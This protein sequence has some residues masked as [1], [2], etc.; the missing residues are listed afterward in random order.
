[1]K[2]DNHVG[3][4]LSTQK[5][6]ISRYELNSFSLN[7]QCV[8]RE[9]CVCVCACVCVCVCVCAHARACFDILQIYRLFIHLN[10]DKNV[11]HCFRCANIIVYL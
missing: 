9:L 7:Y 10:L 5:I 8:K 2:D 11:Y 1:M 6:C 4:D 3:S